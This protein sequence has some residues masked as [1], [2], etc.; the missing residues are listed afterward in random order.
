MKLKLT[1]L[2][3]L[4]CAFGGHWLTVKTAHAVVVDRPFEV[5]TRIHTCAVKDM[6]PQASILPAL[7]SSKSEAAHIIDTTIATMPKAARM[8]LPIHAQMASYV[9]DADSPLPLRKPEIRR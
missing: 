1:L 3:G 7:H 5:E 6:T 4:L 2:F 9:M 8:A